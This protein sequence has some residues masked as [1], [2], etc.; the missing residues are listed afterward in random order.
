MNVLQE[1]LT[2][3]LLLWRLGK[4]WRFT[5]DIWISKVLLLWELESQSCPLSFKWF[6]FWMPFLFQ[7][8][9]TPADRKLGWRAS[10]LD[11]L[12]FESLST[13]TASSTLAAKDSGDS[14]KRSSSEL[15]ISKSIPVIF[16]TRS[17]CRREK[18]EY[19]NFGYWKI[20]ITL[21][22]GISSCH[23]RDNTKWMRQINYDEYL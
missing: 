13:S 20:L 7:L 8:T 14:N 11:T 3:R 12:A 22:Y 18:R 19:I 9:A 21:P 17:G 16:G 10:W 1:K 2:E 5:T 6:L 23:F 4:F 15:S